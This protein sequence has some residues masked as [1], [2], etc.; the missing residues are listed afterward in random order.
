MK[1]PSPQEV[2]DVRS[3]LAVAQDQGERME[4]FMR[5]EAIN[6]EAHFIKREVLE[7]FALDALYTINFDSTYYRWLN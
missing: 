5:S 4:S 7:G 3:L 6:L 1:I 2:V